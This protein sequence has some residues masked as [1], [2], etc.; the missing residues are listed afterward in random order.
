LLCILGRNFPLELHKHKTGWR[1][2]D[3]WM[4]L[5]LTTAGHSRGGTIPGSSMGHSHND[6]KTTSVFGDG[7]NSH[8]QSPVLV[9]KE[10]TW[11]AKKSILGFSFLTVQ[12]EAWKK[13][14]L[15]NQQQPWPVSSCFISKSY[16]LWVIL[17][18]QFRGWTKQ[19]LIKVLLCTKP[20]ADCICTQFL[21]SSWHPCKWR[22][23]F[24][25]FFAVNLLHMLIFNI[26]T[27]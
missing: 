5:V 25:L 8:P 2:W 7:L 22:D 6:S 9:K 3:A 12:D 20:K 1:K 15:W 17:S 26:L 13:I 24:V 19:P 10:V 23:C 14:F 11:E 4:T 18:K 21:L 16:K 27:T